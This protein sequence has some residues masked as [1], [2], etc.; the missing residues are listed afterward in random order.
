MKNKQIETKIF[1]RVVDYLLFTL[2]LTTA[3]TACKQVPKQVAVTQNKAYYTCSMHPQ[4]HEDHD[5][6]CPVCNMKL[7]K[8]EITGTDA[9]IISDIITLTASQIQLANI[10]TDTVREENIGNENTLTGT[11]TTDENRAEQVSARMAGRIQQLFVRTKGEK[12]AIGEPIYSIYSEDLQEAEKEYLL[13]LRQQKLLNNLDVDYKQLISAAENKLKLWGITYAQIRNLAL[14]QKVSPTQ[15][16]Q[17]P[18]NGTVSDIAVHEGDYITEGMPVMKTQ[19][20]STLWVQAQLYGGETGIYKEKD[21][22][23]V[24]FPDLGGEIIK[25]RVEFINPELLDASKVDLIRISIPNKKALIKPGMLAYISLSSGS[26][27]SLAIP[28]TSILADGTGNKVWIKNTDGS[29]T[30]KMV[31]LGV[32]N[33]NY[34][35]IISGLNTGEIVVTKGV[36]LLNSESI[37]KNGN[38]QMGGMKM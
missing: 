29:F 22:V 11:V 34:I 33:Q 17:S 38:N 32:S 35:T 3:L 14:S 12:I 13:A 28:V 8:V 31:K 2:M 27:R 19:T 36:Y 6:K 25:G 15:S 20:L 37:F 4:I 26:Q 18:V 21:E 10:Q 23:T 9:N 7:I 24:S 30:P 16:I 1:N 5:G